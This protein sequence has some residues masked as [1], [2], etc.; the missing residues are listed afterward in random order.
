L[1]WPV[2]LACIN[3][4]FICRF[5]NGR[6][7]YNIE[8]TQSGYGGF[9]SDPDD[10]L[11]TEKILPPIAITSGSDLRA[12]TPREMLGQFIGLRARH[13]RD[14]GISE[15]DEQ[16]ILD[17]EPDW[18]LA[19]SLCPTNRQLYKNQMAI[20]AM[21]GDTLFDHSE[22]GFHPRPL[23]FDFADGRDLVFQMEV[24]SW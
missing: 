13:L 19:R 1:G 23:A 8:A 6:V 12:L 17:S 20:T 9:K 14:V 16:R 4:H 5:D 7:T 2:S 21:R 3:S 10:Y 18:L 22:T 11:I 15:G 24:N